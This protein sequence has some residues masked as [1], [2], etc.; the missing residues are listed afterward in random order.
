M[1]AQ[2]VR[3]ALQRAV[4]PD[5]MSLE[6]LSPYLP[7]TPTGQALTLLVAILIPFFLFSLRGKSADRQAKKKSKTGAQKA[8]KK[9]ERDA[10][11]N[12]AQPSKPKKPTEAT[13]EPEPV[14]D[15]TNGG[16]KKK[17][18]KGAAAEPAPEDEGWEVVSTKK[19]RDEV[20]EHNKRI[21]GFS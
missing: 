13:P 15:T 17:G 8:K 9:A 2:V 5:A 16:K 1:L 3:P 20:A 10:K 12:E 11:E 21:P 7:E 18:K 4:Q 19:K 14:P 6:L